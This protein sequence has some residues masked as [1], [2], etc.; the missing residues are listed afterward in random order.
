VETVLGALLTGVTGALAWMTRTLK[1]RISGPFE[2]FVEH[3]DAYYHKVMV[4]GIGGTGKTTL[5]N[6]ITG[7]PS[8]NPRVATAEYDRHS[9]KQ[10]LVDENLSREWHFSFDD[11]RG[12]NPGVLVQEIGAE[13]A[14]NGQ[15]PSYSAIVLVVDLFPALG[16]VDSPIAPSSQWDRKRV[17]EHLDGWTASMI[18]AFRGFA[19]NASYICL[20]INKYDLVEP[21]SEAVEK[22]ILR[23]FRPLIERLELNSRGALFE[24]HVGSLTADV[25]VMK[26]FADLV[27]TAKHVK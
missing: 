4:L 20:F 1:K 17:Q 27:T 13:A 12:Q 5:I 9:V 8:A 26:V 15:T 19:P 2:R 22:Q 3:H 10:A 18:A 14:R 21:R 6:R 11:Y 23:A 7:D 24:V 16:E 25:G